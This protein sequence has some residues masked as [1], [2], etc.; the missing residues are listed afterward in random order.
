[1]FRVGDIVGF[2]WETTD[3]VGLIVEESADVFEEHDDIDEVLNDCGFAVPVSVPIFVV[4][5]NGHLTRWSP[6][7][8]ALIRRQ[9]DEINERG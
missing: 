4:L 5:L 2:P 6:G 7:N 8:L 3:E 9:T 1:M